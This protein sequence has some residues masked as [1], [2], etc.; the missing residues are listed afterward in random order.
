MSAQNELERY[1]RLLHIATTEMYQDRPDAALETIRSVR[2]AIES[3]EGN[4]EWAELPLVIGH[5]LTAQNK[6]EALGYLN[7]ALGRIE[8]LHDPP[9]ELRIR[10]LEHLGNFHR[11]CAR[12]RATA[13]E[14][15][16]KAK[17]LADEAGFTEDSDKLELRICGIDLENDEDPGYDD[18][19]TL[20]GVG[21][22]QGFTAREQLDVWNS[23]RA[24]TTELTKTLKGARKF[25]SSASG[26]YFLNLLKS[27][28]NEKSAQ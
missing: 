7:Q 23:Y 18:Y 10:A 27:K 22:Q 5:A 1:R 21:R 2:A 8:E 9:L 11:L 13:R 19:V 20:V 15:Y 3:R 17:A 12:R 16:I 6:E 25:G 14:F 26:T 4:L 28:R 24:R